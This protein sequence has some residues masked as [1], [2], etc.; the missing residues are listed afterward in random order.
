MARTPW[1]GSEELWAATATEALKEGHEVYLSALD[2][3]EPHPKLQRLMEKGLQV[4][5]RKKALPPGT[6]IVKRVLVLGYY[7]IQHRLLGAYRKVLK[8]G[9]D[10]VVYSGTCY[11]IAKDRRLL[12]E[13]RTG[14]A[15]FFIITQLNEE[16]IR[17]ISDEEAEV[18]RQAYRK[19]ERVFFVSARN[20]QTAQRH[21]C[22][23]VENAKVI[24]NPVNMEEKSPLPFP[25]NTTVQMAMVGNLITLHKGQDLALA[26][27]GRPE[28]KQRNWQLNL[29]GDGSD[30][31][32]L[33]RLCDYYGIRE[34]VVFHGRVSDIRGLWAVNQLLLM[35]SLIEGM[36]LAIVEAM[37]CARPAVVTDI[38]GHKE[39]ISEG[40]EGFVAEATSVD[41]LGNAMERAWQA[42]DNWE[43][44]GRAAHERAIAQ[45]D[46]QPGKTLWEIL[47]EK[48]AH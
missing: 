1:G 24:R 8:P 6:G 9:P 5:Y 15:R 44:M 18:I 4:S 10:I 31:A 11:S 3:G 48:E 22:T 7:Y 29:Y 39:W 42:R 38:G 27:L 12:Q 37:L 32:Y 46:P 47:L 43:A 40:K 45:Y 14:K 30:R 25:V 28:W 26:V 21:L 17:P 2:T 33:E 35:P 36:P 19:A 23:T 41:S 16:V 13:M 20:L 34:K